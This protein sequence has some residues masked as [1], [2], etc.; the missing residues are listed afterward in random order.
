M[1]NELYHVTF[2]LC[3]I[4]FN[5]FLL[6]MSLIQVKYL[7][8]ENDQIVFYESVVKTISLNEIATAV[9]KS[10]RIFRFQ[11]NKNDENIRLQ[12]KLPPKISTKKENICFW[13]IFIF[14]KD[15]IQNERNEY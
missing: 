1:R 11:R 3:P 12:R 10:N 13:L 8:F 14:K 15:F 4:N 2:C 7:F 5:Q 9:N 6:L